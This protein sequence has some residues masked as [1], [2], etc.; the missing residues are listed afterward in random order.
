MNLIDVTREL[1]TEQDCFAFL[2][3]QRWPDGV[4][5]AVCGCDRIS[6][7]ERKS[8]SK[9]L[10]K[11]LYQCLEPTCKQ[12]FSVTSGTIF[13]NSRIPLTKWFMAIHMLMDAKKSISALQLQ[14]HLGISSYQTV[15]H[16]AHRIRKAMVGNESANLTG[17]VEMD[18]SYIG[19][20]KRGRKY[21]G[22]RDHKACVV[23]IKQ[24][25]GDLRLIHA[26]DAKIETLARYL[27]LHV[28]SDVEAIMTDEL[29]AYPKALEISGHDP[30]KHYTVNH[31][32]RIWAEGEIT[33]N[34]IESAF[35]LFK[36]GIVGSF[37]HI[38][39]K[40]LH[41]YLNEFSH[42]FNRRKMPTRFNDL[43]SRSGQTS[44][45][46]YRDLVGK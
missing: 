27:K 45:L 23:G 41:R 5:C 1:G 17:I 8:K 14:R 42:R 37:H 43:V 40:H 31:S 44:P 28:S 2:E 25:G 10:R 9:N 39:A 26:P 33:T 18:E 16:M 7:I 6:R 34:G 35:S 46:F 38:S 36:R 15:W 22:R 13:H 21:Q 29:P 12:Q 11:N 30:D 32:A 19:G 20:T 4:R 3:R 24:R